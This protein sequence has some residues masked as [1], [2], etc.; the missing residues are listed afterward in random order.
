MLLWM[1]MLIMPASSWALHLDGSIAQALLVNRLESG[2]APLLVDVRTPGEFQGGHVP[3]A[4]NIPLQELNRRMDE[5]RPY[6]DT[7]LVLYCETGIRAGYAGRML[8][9]QGFTELRSLGG[10]MQAWRNAGLP[11][12]R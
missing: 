11:A 10:H 9:Q 7:E 12:E 4:I 3:G 8:K 5:L 2:Q 1:A 6:R